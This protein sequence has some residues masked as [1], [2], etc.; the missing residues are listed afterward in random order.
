MT[1][2]DSPSATLASTER[3][4]CRLE[5]SAR[6]ISALRAGVRRAGLAG[7]GGVARRRSAA[8][9]MTGLVEHEHAAGE[10]LRHR[11]AQGRQRGAP[12]EQRRH[13]LVRLG[14]GLNAAHVPLELGARL[15]GLVERGAGAL[16]VVRVLQRDGAVRG[17][18]AEDGDALRRVRAVISIGDEEQ[19]DHFAVPDQRHADQRGDA[20]DRERCRRAWDR[21]RSA[22]RAGS[23]AS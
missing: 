11:L 10:Q 14:G 22:C 18:R 9:H 5:L 6:A 2:H 12:R 3:P 8:D 23:R 4:N 15:L 16:E 1:R 13:L 7:A 21:A 20:F 19:A 17:Q